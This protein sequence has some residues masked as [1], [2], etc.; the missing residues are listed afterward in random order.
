MEHVFSNHTG[1]AT[2]RDDLAGDRV[3]SSARGLERATPTSSKPLTPPTVTCVSFDKSMDTSA[4]GGGGRW[5][6]EG[7]SGEVG[8]TAS[9]RGS[10]TAP[11]EGAP[12]AAWTD[13]AEVELA[14]VVGEYVVSAAG[15]HQGSADA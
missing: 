9:A 10:S 7:G 14:F 1:T 5:R 15:P 13:K 11:R 6:G 4:G 3:V 2:R 12:V 8:C